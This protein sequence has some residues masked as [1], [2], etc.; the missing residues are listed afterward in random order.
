MDPLCDLLV[1]FALVNRIRLPVGSPA[2][3]T[4]KLNPMNSQSP[5]ARL[6]SRLAA[7]PELADWA[8]GF[9][10]IQHTAKTILQIDALRERLEKDGRLP[11]EA[12]FFE[13]LK[14]ADRLASAAM[15]LVVHETYAKNVYLDGR[16]LE[17]TDFKAR[18][19]G[20]TGGALNMAVAFAA[21]VAANAM[22]G[23]T[24]A[25][26]MGQGHTV[27][28]VDSVNLLSGNASAAHAAR[29]DITDEGLSR[30]VRDF[31]SC[32][33]NDQGRQDSP[34]G[35][36]V[37]VHTA[38][39]LSEGGYLG[40]AELMYVHMP[41][42]GEK[43]VVFL[44]DGAFEEQRGSDWAPRW[45]RAEDCGLCVPIMMNNGRR[46]DQ[47]TTLSMQGGARWLQQHLKLNGFDPI[48]FDGRDPAAF[49]YI[50]L[51]CERR[52]ALRGSAQDRKY[53]VPLPYGIAVTTKGFGFHGAGTNAAHNLPLPGV[54]ASDEKARRL[55]NKSAKALHVPL[56]E[57]RAAL[58]LFDRHKIS[59]RPREREHPLVVRNV[60][61]HKPADLA[62]KIITGNPGDP[63]SL[64]RSCPMAAVDAGFVAS[65]KANPQL[66]PRV[67]NPDE[68]RSNRM[69]T[70]LD[71]LKHRV[72]HPEPGVAES[73]D[74]AV[75]TALNEEAVACAALANEA[76]LNIIVS[77]EA[78]AA[79]MHGILRQ[80]IIFSQQ[81]RDHGITPQWLSVPLVLTS[82]LWE[83][84]KNEHSHQ[85]PSLCEALMMEHACESRV[86]FPA[87][88][89]SAAAAMESI[90]L[91]KGEIWTLVVPKAAAIPDV[92]D[93]PA[94]RRLVTDGGIRVGGAGFEPE[95]ARVA[96]TAVGSY[97]LSQ[98]L[99]ASARLAE[100][101]IPHIVNYILEPSRFRRGRDSREAARAAARSVVESLFPPTL[102]A[103]LHL[104]HGHGEVLAG[105]LN[106]LPAGPRDSVLGYNNCG[107]TLDIQEMLFINR[108]TWAHAVCEVS[109]LL[110]LAPDQLLTTEELDSL[111]CR[112]NPSGVL[113]R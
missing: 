51:E 108:S 1:S 12:G 34:L 8:R 30:Y 31:Y 78:F 43:L 42:P 56:V 76:G 2:T 47:R 107:G 39:G 93:G 99:R 59:G 61:Y 48:V 62:F 54:P 3:T 75:I 89:N 14:A 64:S 92:F 98:S 87:D 44:S 29:Y 58:Q 105:V 100:R 65:V 45:W 104:F 95:R 26:L 35:S 20:H 85:D 63:G 66:R 10:V 9:G 13:L 84:G 91:T 49:I 71:L 60:H 67:G 90:Y 38:G 21:Y 37:N 4:P 69:G 86:M 17:S 23:E 111:A 53:P 50:I 82:H 22:T 28:A 15:W 68:L 88:Y 102:D 25:W 70:T 46:I 73:Q 19:E 57:L 52:L 96:L 110:R 40:F 27:A 24:R 36:H 81:M 18:P 77:Y 113:F 106:H 16:A 109:Q 72:T 5:A 32:K 80:K 55:F 7:S 74:G 94:A 97:Q 11:K 6:K 33:L 103:R 101:R 79:K 112:R 83:N 41:L